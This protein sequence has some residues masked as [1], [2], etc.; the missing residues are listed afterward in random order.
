[1]GLAFDSHSSL[2]FSS[3][4]HTSSLF[5]FFLSPGSR[6]KRSSSRSR[7]T[8]VGSPLL[9]CHT[10]PHS[11]A[12][13]SVNLLKGLALDWSHPWHCLAALKEHNLGHIQVFW[14][15]TKDRVSFSVNTL[16]WH[17]V[18]A[19]THRNTE[20]RRGLLYHHG[21][22]SSCASGGNAWKTLPVSSP[23][24]S[25]HFRYFSFLLKSGLWNCTAKS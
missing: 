22:L 3:L 7:W 8:K 2:L 1:M 4:L 13:T 6:R 5:P 18:A 17:S 19:L 15:T 20:Q 16:A 21:M 9:F 14:S 11:E 23:P 10:V 24:P 12:S 25:T